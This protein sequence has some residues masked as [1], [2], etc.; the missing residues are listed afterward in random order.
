MRHLPAAIA[1]AVITLSSLACQKDE[2]VPRD[3][4]IGVLVWD[5]NDAVHSR[6]RAARDKALRT[7]T[8]LGPD[9]VA[10][11]RRVALLSKAD[12]TTG[13]VGEFPELQ[14][15]IGRIYAAVDGETPAV[16]AGV[17]EQY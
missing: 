14:G 8:D 11:T 15:I 10:E 5:F 1:L 17:E 2:P 12:L 9:A 16:S 4:R 7:L 3:L 13:M 6:D